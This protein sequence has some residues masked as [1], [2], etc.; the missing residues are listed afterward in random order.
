MTTP[1]ARGLFVTGTDTNVGKT[2]I[3]AMLA[4]ALRAS[5][6][7]PG[8]FKP[9]CSGAEFT[10]HGPV[11]NDIEVHFNALGGLV[12]RDRICPQRFTA[13]LAPPLAA[14][15]EGR[16]LDEDIW[17]QGLNWWRDQCDWLL[18]EGVGGFLCPLSDDSTIADFASRLRFPLLIVARAGL[19]TINHTLLTIEAI[20]ARD[21]PIL[22]VILNDATPA[23]D[24]PSRADNAREIARRGGC[25][26][27]AEISYHYLP[28]LPLHTNP[29]TMRTPPSEPSPS[30]APVMEP[31]T[32][33]RIL[34]LVVQLSG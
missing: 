13:P 31:R 16:Q 17:Q 29:S 6:Q 1:S 20:R 7:R 8:I 3:T 5:G 26:V 32:L 4:R 25:P 15:A 12:D 22:G 28:D 10:P 2:V 21:L 19:G 24:D 23:V 9:V 14:R 18:V 11:W 30:A 27:L 34:D 33:A